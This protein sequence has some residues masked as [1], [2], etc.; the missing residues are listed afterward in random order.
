MDPD[1]YDNDQMENDS[2][3]GLEEE[4]GNIDREGE[5]EGDEYDEDIGDGFI[6]AGIPEKLDR[7]LRACLRCK[8]CIIFTYVLI[9]HFK[10][11]KQSFFSLI[12]TK[13]QFLDDGCEN[14]SFLSMKHDDYRVDEV[15]KLMRNKICIE[16][17]LV[18]PISPFS[19]PL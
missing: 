2:D 8:Y 12:K 1:D 3:N 17:R 7:N 10:I 16:K 19:R 13:I 9:L 4:E 18:I 11:T 6:R 15:L 5:G 14:C